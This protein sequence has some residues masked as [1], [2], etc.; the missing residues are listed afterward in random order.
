M[1]TP[2]LFTI[3]CRSPLSPPFPPSPLAAHH[4]HP[5][6]ERDLQL[7]QAI[8]E[9][10]AFNPAALDVPPVDWLAHRLALVENAR[11]GTPNKRLTLAHLVLQKL[12]AHATAATF[13]AASLQRTVL[14]LRAATR[15][16]N[17]GLAP[18]NA[19]VDEELRGS[20]NGAVLTILSKL[21]YTWEQHLHMPKT[22]RAVVAMSTQ[23]LSFFEL[24]R[25]VV[26]AQTPAAEKL[27]GWVDKLLRVLCYLAKSSLRNQASEACARCVECDAAGVKAHACGGTAYSI[28]SRV[29]SAQEATEFSFGSTDYV[30]QASG[31]RLPLSHSVVL[32]S[33]TLPSYPRAYLNDAPVVNGDVQYVCLLEDAETKSNLVTVASSALV[34]LV[35]SEPT[36]LQRVPLAVAMRNLYIEPVNSK[37]TERWTID[38]DS[39]TFSSNVTANTTLS[40]GAAWETCSQLRGD[41]ASEFV[42]V[43]MMKH[44]RCSPSDIQGCLH[45]R[46][47]DIGQYACQCQQ[48]STALG[49]YDLPSPSGKRCVP[50]VQA[51]CSSSFPSPQLL[52]HAQQCTGSS[53]LKYGRCVCNEG[54]ACHRGVCEEVKVCGDVA[55]EGQCE[56]SG[57]RYNHTSFLC[58]CSDGYLCR[59]DVGAPRYSTCVRRST[60]ASQ[61]EVHTDECWKGSVFQQETRSCV[62]DILMFCHPT[63]EQCTPKARCSEAPFV[64]AEGP[65]ESMCYPG[66]VV[67]PALLLVPSQTSATGYLCGCPDALTCDATLKAC[68]C[69]TCAAGTCDYTAD[70]SLWHTLQHVCSCPEGRVGATCAKAEPR[71]GTF[72]ELLYPGGDHAAAAAANT[73]ASSWATVKTKLSDKLLEVVMRGPQAA[74]NTTPA[75]VRS[76]YVDSG[77]IVVRFELDVFP[78][79]WAAWLRHRLTQESFGLEMAATL[80]SAHASTVNLGNLEAVNIS[81]LT[82]CDSDSGKPDAS[83][84]NCAARP[85]P[86]QNCTCET[87]ASGYT[88][89]DGG[90]TCVNATVCNAVVHCSGRGST[91]GLVVDGCQC[92]C[93]ATFEGLACE[94]D[95]CVRNASMWARDDCGRARCA[96]RFDS[97]TEP[98]SD[99]GECVGPSSGAF[100]R[101]AIALVVISGLLISV[102]FLQAIYWSVKHHCFWEREYMRWTR[103]DGEGGGKDTQDIPLD[104]VQYKNEGS[105]DENSMTSESIHTSRDARSGIVSGVGRSRSASGLGSGLGRAGSASGSITASASGSA[106]TLGKRSG[107]G[108]PRSVTN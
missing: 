93:D 2:T 29:V 63:T 92:T 7:D 21:A 76:V 14:V 6:S 106:D 33:Y 25:E 105:D 91:T 15:F 96:V 61:Q 30:K 16:A 18:H 28:R 34:V 1:C 73:A 32:A 107:G 52:A 103:H 35:N 99:V 88:T 55:S 68:T 89:Q 71:N 20:V 94:T 43:H 36:P 72:L 42:S 54:A 78:S 44:R 59:R 38:C 70:V 11:I 45:V 40:T 81:V 12:D 24:K 51:N 100:S 57:L 69:P 90:Q 75:L 47:E 98:G 9:V 23:L 22:R 10:T 58:E 5:H 80:R 17:T 65:S 4:T 31:T 104:M 86:W 85:R 13:S 41:T 37:R 46:N 64:P 56:L 84:E 8:A 83:I 53:M 74:V 87:C 49:Y 77:S 82:L 95:L 108:F 60:C 62:C 27:Q 48:C 97:N 101:I 50:Y 39:A 67:Q 79:A 19:A 66:S 102:V 3:S 26:V